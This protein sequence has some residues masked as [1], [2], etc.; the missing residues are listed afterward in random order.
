MNTIYETL[1]SNFFGEIAKLLGQYGPKLLMSLV[2][3]LIGLW[4]I[5]ILVKS[6]SKFI[7]NRH[8]DESL[9][10]FLITLFDFLLKITLF[11][12]VAAQIGVKTTSFLAILG[13]AG[14]AVGLALQGSLA[15]FAAGVLILIFKPYKVGDL[16]E[17]QDQIGFVKEI[18]VFVTKLETFQ[19]KTA[20]IPNGPLLGGNIINYSENGKI[21]ADI[22]FAIRYGEDIDKAKSI[23]QNIMDS[24]QYVLKDPASSVYVS[25]LTNENVQFTALAFTTVEDYWEVYWGLKEK[26]VKELGGAGYDVPFERFRLQKV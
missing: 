24:S 7:S 19:L 6:L 12:A 26:I 5:K 22:N 14:L 16:I 23:V 10:P 13:A 4:I 21:R 9:R 11:L 25:E 3:L 2:T 18:S 17:T 15:N 1:K 8:I 20:I